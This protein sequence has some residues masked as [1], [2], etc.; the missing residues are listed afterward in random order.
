VRYWLISHHYRKPITFSWRK[1]ETARK[2]L[3]RLD[4][5]VKKLMNSRNIT[6]CRP[7]MDQLIY[8]LRR[9]SLDALDDDLNVAKALAALFQ[10]IRRI[11]RIMDRTGLSPEDRDKV[12][13]AL[14]TA[15]SVLGVMN[16]KP[17]KP[18][19][20][21]QA[22]VDEREAARRSGDWE[23]ADRIRDELRDVG[24]EVIDT[25]E[26]PVLKH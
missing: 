25:R 16:L 8:D 9:S 24:V 2:T 14:E 18:D 13:E 26:G 15:D 23:K 21:L 7:E 17:D 22:L 1:L 3:A 12:L 6:S 19:E 5:F 20:G 10:F 4:T 11:N